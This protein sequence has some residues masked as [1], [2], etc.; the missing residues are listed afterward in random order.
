[1][2]GFKK[3]YL[4]PLSLEFAK[5]RTRLPYSYGHR[6]HSCT[7]TLAGVQIDNGE[8][9]RHGSIGYHNQAGDYCRV[10]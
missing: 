6:P 10:V 9:A 5:I 4:Y 3:V 1:M 7:V 8:G 2:L